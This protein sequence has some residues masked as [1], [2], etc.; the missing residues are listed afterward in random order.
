MAA[1]EGGLERPLRCFPVELLVFCGRAAGVSTCSGSL[2][3]LRTCQY[4]L[5]SHGA[6]WL[7]CRL[8]WRSCSFLSHPA[9][10]SFQDY[11]V[12]S[13]EGGP[14]FASVQVLSLCFRA[15]IHFEGVLERISFLGVA[16]KTLYSGYARISMKTNKPWA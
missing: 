11:H 9:S 14:P 16:R 10:V 13:C 1:V 5:S 2:I 15:F 7:W 3:R 8:T 12:C 4:L 6:S